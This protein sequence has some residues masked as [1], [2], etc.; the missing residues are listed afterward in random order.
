MMP[1]G[2]YN[3]YDE[4]NSVQKKSILQATN[5]TESMNWGSIEV[6]TPRFEILKIRKKAFCI[7]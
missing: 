2:K 6:Q 1:P 3:R 5:V 7:Y 4:V